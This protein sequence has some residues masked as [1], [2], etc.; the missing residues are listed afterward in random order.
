[1]HVVP[2]LVVAICVGLY[3][4]ITRFYQAKHDPREPPLL[5]QTIPIIGHVIGMLRK[6]GRYY[7]QLR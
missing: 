3:Y 1:M 6:K 2:P 4:A 5:S 7:V